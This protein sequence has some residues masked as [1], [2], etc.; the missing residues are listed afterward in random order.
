MVRRDGTCCSDVGLA[1]GEAGPPLRVCTVGSDEQ[2]KAGTI[3]YCQGDGQGQTIPAFHIISEYSQVCQLIK[4]S[5]NIT[6][7]SVK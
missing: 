2:Q 4:T 3:K 6:I 7:Y 5:L 1:E